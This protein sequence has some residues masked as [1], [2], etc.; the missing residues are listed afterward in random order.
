[1]RGVYAYLCTDCNHLASEHLWHHTQGGTLRDGPYVC[2]C[3]CK[4]PQDG[5]FSPMDRKGYET[6]MAGRA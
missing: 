4:Q 1:M 2:T 5:P 3:G 6:Y